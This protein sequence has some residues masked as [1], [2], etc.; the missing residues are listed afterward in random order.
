MST[1]DPFKYFYFSFAQENIFSNYIFTLNIHNLIPLKYTVVQA[2][3]L[4]WELQT[5]S[6]AM[7]GR[8]I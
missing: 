4:K 7:L 2:G 3:I 8:N 5:K 1:V 6:I